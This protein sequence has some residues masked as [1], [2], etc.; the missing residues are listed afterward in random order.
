MRKVLSIAFAALLL[1]VMSCSSS[2]SGDVL[3]AKDFNDTMTKLNDEL[4]V[5]VRTPGEYSEGHLDHAVNIDWTDN[6]FETKIA[7]WDKS[8]PVMV[9]CQSGR[10]S[11]AAGNKM[12][13][14]G[15]KKVY[16]L[17]GGITAWIDENLPVVN[18]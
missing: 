5:D 2:S 12:R 11:A 10:R 18:N 17:S 16:E 6:S 14:M 4:L 8:K 9:Y 1:T 3:S 15:F 13:D 7:N